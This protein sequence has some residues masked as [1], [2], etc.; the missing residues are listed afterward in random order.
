MRLSPDG[1][2]FWQHGFVKLN[3]TIVFT[4][5][6]MLVLAVGS[7]LITRKLSLDLKRSRWQNLLEIVVAA[8]EK[9]I[10]DVGLSHPEKYLGFLGTLFLFI[11]LSNFLY[12]FS[13]LRAA[14]EFA[15]DHDGTGAVRIFGRAA[16]R[17]RGAGTG[18]LPQVLRGANA[19]HVAVQHHQR[20]LAHTG[21]G[22]P[23]VRQHDERGD[24]HRHSAHHHALHLPNRHDGARSAHRAWCR[25]I[26][27]S[28]WPRFTSQLPLACAKPSLSHRPKLETSTTKQTK[29]ITW[30]T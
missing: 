20:A 25:P 17:H 24:D 9:Q 29:D 3:A 12:D 15:L 28:S 13:R 1:M 5:G 21:P 27:S 8:I 22:R 10:K 19:P 6:L 30:I 23:S 4:W 26:F 14:D 7:K 16:V 18:R 2:I 11:A